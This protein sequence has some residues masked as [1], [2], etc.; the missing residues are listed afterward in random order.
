MIQMKHDMGMYG[1]SWAW[2]DF[3]RVAF[4][5]TQILGHEHVGQTWIALNRDPY[6]V[7]ISLIASAVRQMAPLCLDGLDPECNAGRDTT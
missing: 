6:P 7:D 4:L 1:D 3:F 2:L 5:G